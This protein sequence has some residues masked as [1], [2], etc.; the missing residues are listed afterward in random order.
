MSV[1]D[2]ARVF[3]NRRIAAT[4]QLFVL[5]LVLGVFSYFMS[6]PPWRLVG[7]ITLA[8]GFFALFAYIIWTDKYVIAPAPPIAEPQPLPSFLQIKG[9]GIRL[10]DDFVELLEKL[11]TEDN[12]D[13][14]NWLRV[15]LR[16]EDD[17]RH[18][19]YGS[20]RA[21]LVS[22]GRHRCLRPKC[23]ENGPRMVDNPKSGLA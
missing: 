17:V 7:S 2:Y 11:S 4:L 12:T 22:T 14:W 13:P 10:E 5:S 3:R 15:T 21:P 1:E 6:Q 18:V 9:T 19:T 20:E 23:T 8:S 16:N